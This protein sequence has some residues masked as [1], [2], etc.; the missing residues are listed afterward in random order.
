VRNIGNER[1]PGKTGLI[2]FGMTACSLARENSHTQPVSPQA[3]HNPALRFNSDPTVGFSQKLSVA[4][5]LQL[6]CAR[7]RKARETFQLFSHLV[8]QT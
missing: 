1:F 7:Q 4:V 6:A 3:R 5:G 8:K 2:S